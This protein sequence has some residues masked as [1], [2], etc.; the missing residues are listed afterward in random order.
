MDQDITNRIVSLREKIRKHDQLYYVKNQ[1]EISDQD[2][3]RLFAELKHLEAENPTLITPDS[4]TQRVAG[5]PAPGFTSIKHKHPMLSLEKVYTLEEVEAFDKRVRSELSPISDVVYCLEPKVDG[6]SISVKYHKGS[7]VQGATR[8]DGEAGEDVTNNV[9][10]IRNIPLAL[11]NLPQ[12]FSDQIE[13]RGEVYMGKLAFEKL[14]AARAAA[15]EPLFANPRNAAAGSLRQL[16]PKVTATRY[17]AAVFYFLYG[18]NPDELPYHHI[19]LLKSIEAM[20]LPVVPWIEARTVDQIKD[21]IEKIRKME[22]DGVFPYEIDGIVIKVIDENIQKALGYTSST[23]KWAVAYKYHHEQ[24]ETTLKSITVQVGR[25]G[26]LTPVAELEPVPLDGS[27]IARATLHNEDEI[28]RKDIRIGDTVL[29]E[30]MGLII[31]GIVEV[32][33]EKRPPDA[34]PFDLK[35]HLHNQCPVCSGTISRDPEEAVW[36]CENISCPARL[37]RSIRHFVSRQAMDVDGV[38]DELVDQLVEKGLVTDLASLYELTEESLK[39]LERMGDKSSA[40]ILDAIAHSKECEL[41]RLIH[42]LGIKGIG[43]TAARKLAEKYASLEQLSTAGRE[44]LQRIDGFGDIL[45]ESVIGYFGNQSNRGLL[46]R[47]SKVGV[48]PKAQ[49]SVAIVESPFNGK[50]VCVTGTLSVPREQIHEELRK[51]G[52]KV[53]DSVS[54]KTDFLIAGDKAGSKLEKAK[55]AGVKVLTEAEFKEM[56]N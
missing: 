25:T 51:L 9:R 56:T 47:L 41:W 3:D 53:V 26:S 38:G 15:G 55:K 19:G 21:G 2:Y 4:P 1:P 10:T 32:V 20:N 36:R 40:N 13:V 28:K 45:C 14:N 34:K 42:G 31:P 52:A 39:S 17:L 11:E 5:S 7:M 24:A 8:G 50:S 35:E 30:K 33:L 23:P 12:G 44:D 37:K 49:E 27:V 46:T 18:Q 29:I 16:D 43:E 48:K 22:A 6:L 54:K